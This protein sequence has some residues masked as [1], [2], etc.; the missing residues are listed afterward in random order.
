[1]FWCALTPVPHESPDLIPRACDIGT[2]KRADVRP[3]ATIDE[4]ITQNTFPLHP[5]LPSACRPA[6]PVTGLLCAN[7]AGIP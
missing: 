1:M 4:V 7:L 5:S 6:R 3:P 2:G